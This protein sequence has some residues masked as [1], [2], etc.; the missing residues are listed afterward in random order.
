[1]ANYF[2]PKVSSD[3]NDTIVFGVSNSNRTKDFGLVKVLGYRHDRNTN[4]E[5]VW[6]TMQIILD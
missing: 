6:D 3:Y 2:K 5:V 4:I 1:M